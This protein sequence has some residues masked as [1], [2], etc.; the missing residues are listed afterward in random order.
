MKNSKFIYAVSTLTGT[1]IGVG[2]FSLPYIT[3]KAGF[4]I[5]IGYFAVISL[6]A[7][8]VHQMLGEIALKTSDF[9]RFPGFV[10]V[11]LGRFGEKIAYTSNILGLFGALL[12]YSIIGGKFL[13]SLFFPLIGEN[14]I[15]W[16][17]SYFI[18]GSVLILIG[19]KLVSKIE[20]WGL[21]LF[22]FA[23]IAIFFKGFSTIEISNFFP[24]TDLNEFFLPYGP[25][26][27]S[28]WGAALIPEAE[29]LLRGEKR[30]L[31]KAILISILIAVFVYLF[32]I[33]LTLGISGPQ[34]T[35]NA[36][37]GLKNV[38]GNGVTSLALFVAVLTSFTSFITV[39][40]TLKKIFAY[41]LKI[42]KNL[43]WLIACFVPLI[44][45]LIGIQNFIQV[46]S[47]IGGAVLGVDG[48]LILLMYRKIRPEKRFLIIPLILI[49][50]GGIIYEIIYS[51][52]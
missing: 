23:L 48:I 20:F 16:T 30:L 47:F 45:F 9:S 27:F 17:V 38:L 46:I 18:I 28:L 31:R 19:I 51:I 49:F 7:V 10:K 32:F 39:G 35:E 6:I 37:T 52:K 42:N 36:L 2:I 5:I 4:W 1:I 8:L 26:L 12:A 3:L 33:F 22:F 43:S 50:L 24:P 34:T 29:E 11:H 40:L 14:P 15:L 44:L 13:N 41:D 21:I 25:I